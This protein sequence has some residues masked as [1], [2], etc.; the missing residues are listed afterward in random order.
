MIDASH[1]VPF[2]SSP[3]RTEENHAEVTSAPEANGRGLVMVD[4]LSGD[5]VEAVQY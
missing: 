3:L 2:V 4:A 1:F 5:V